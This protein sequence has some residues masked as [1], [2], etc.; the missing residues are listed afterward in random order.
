M[1][2]FKIYYAIEF[3]YYCFNFRQLKYKLEKLPN[4]IREIKC[5]KT[6]NNGQS[7]PLI[8]QILKEINLIKFK[9]CVNPFC[10][11]LNN[12]VSIQKLIRLYLYCN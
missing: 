5:F 10:L 12:I 7:D 2:S 4:K 8:F 3:S 1:Q 6:D 11:T 9:I